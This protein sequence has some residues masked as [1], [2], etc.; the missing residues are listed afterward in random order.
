MN[1]EPPAG[2][3][4]AFDADAAPLES[5][6]GRLGEIRLLPWDAE[7]FGFAVADLR[8]DPTAAESAGGAML[9]RALESWARRE[10]AALVGCRIGATAGGS[11]L[12][13]QAAGFRF[14]D[15]QLR[16]TRPPLAAALERPRLTFR[17]AESADRDRL[18]DIALRAFRFGRYHAD[19]EFPDELASR[20]YRDW[21]GR[22]LDDS[23]PETRV[24]V[25]GEPGAPAG[26]VHT[27]LARE[28]GDV[29]LIASDPGAAPLAGPALLLGAVRDLVERGAARVTALI[30]AANAATLNLYAPLGFR[31][32]DPE[33]V[34]HWSLPG[35]ALRRRERP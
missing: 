5:E 20:R 34:F 9:S 12:I 13:L 8:L 28:I 2:A 31:F 3:R 14:V 22:A 27:V 16:A 23:S 4:V 18:A 33:A 25:V 7:T 24:G 10:N 19:P 35:G 6:A 26:F 32:H 29:R 21:I 15:L 17:R 11:S 1:A 30:S